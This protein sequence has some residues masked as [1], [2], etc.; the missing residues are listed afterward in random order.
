[1]TARDAR[2]LTVGALVYPLGTVLAAWIFKRS[3]LYPH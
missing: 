3:V 1:M 2:W